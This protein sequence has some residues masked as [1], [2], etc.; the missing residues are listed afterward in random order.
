MYIPDIWKGI[1]YN[2][3]W[4]YKIRRIVKICIVCESPLL[5]AR[6]PSSSPCW[7]A[8]Y[9][10]YSIY[11]VCTRG[12]RVLVWPFI[13]LR[14]IARSFLLNIVIRKYFKLCYSFPLQAI[15]NGVISWTFIQK[16]THIHT[17]I[18]TCI[19]VYTH[20]A[21]FIGLWKYV[22]FANLAHRA[23]VCRVFYRFSQRACVWVRV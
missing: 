10:S 21:G 18:Q 13:L 23:A 2:S 14:S 7:F 9:S 8:I 17:R 19:L 11:F 12:F 20:G 4:M 5:F 22:L 15:K 16:H 1:I 6:E 3:N